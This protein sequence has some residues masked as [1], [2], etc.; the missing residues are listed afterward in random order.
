MARSSYLDET[1]GLISSFA[2]NEGLTRISFFLCQDLRLNSEKI[3]QTASLDLENRDLEIHNSV[4]Y[5]TPVANDTEST[6]KSFQ[7]L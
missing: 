1:T 4:M 7:K 5:V 3:A 6:L 2:D